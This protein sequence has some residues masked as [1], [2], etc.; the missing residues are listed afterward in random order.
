LKL[1]I[2][3]N[4]NEGLEF[5]TFCFC[6]NGYIVHGKF[7]EIN[8]YNGVSNRPKYSKTNFGI[9]LRI[10]SETIFNLHKDELL[11]LKKSEPIINEV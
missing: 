6:R 8:S 10:K 11:S 9:N 3:D 5:R 2:N 4:E 1:L 7:D